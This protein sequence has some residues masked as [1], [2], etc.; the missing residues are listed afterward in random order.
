MVDKAQPPTERIAC[1][2]L[3]SY[4]Q[5]VSL[6][7]CHGTYNTDIAFFKRRGSFEQWWNTILC[8]SIISMVIALYSLKLIKEKIV[9]ILTHICLWHL[10]D[11]ENNIR[12]SW[13]KYFSH[14]GEK[15][16]AFIEIS[17]DYHKVHSYKLVFKNCSHH[18]ILR[19]I[20]TLDRP[21]QGIASRCFA[22]NGRIF[23]CKQISQ[24]NIVHLWI[25]FSDAWGVQNENSFS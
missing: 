18:R 6:F 23:Q 2:F 17:S 15:E 20:S 12:A 21:K 25:P 16:K 1:I 10:W 24:F 11:S 8:F 7:L 4:N 19:K 13:I 5:L 14:F 22:L 9:C 3:L